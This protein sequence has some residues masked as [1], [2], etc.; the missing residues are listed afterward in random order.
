VRNNYFTARL[1]ATGKLGF[2]F[3]QKSSAA[4]HMLVY[5]VAGDLIDEYL[6]MSE[7]TCLESMYKFCK[8]V[9]AVFGTVYLRELT[10]EDT[11]RLLSI[12]EEGSG[13]T[14]HFHG[15]TS[16]AAMPRVA[17]SFLRLWHRKI[18][19]SGTLFWHGRLPQ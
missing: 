10:I 4:I 8:V 9:I 7:S 2:T 12:N 14:A 17:R 6:Q 19:G 3:Y 15:N 16:I 1:D 5:E 18:F 13:R 11:A